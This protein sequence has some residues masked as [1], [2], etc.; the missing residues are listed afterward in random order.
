MKIARNLSIALILFISFVHLIS[1]TGCANIIPPS[2]GPRDSLPP[3]LIS[4]APRDS[5]TNF[6]AKTITLN[7]D[8]YVDI[9]N[10]QQNIIIS[11]APKY[12]PIIDRK[13]RTVTIKIK[14]TLQPNTTYLFDFGKAIKDVNEGNVLKNFSYVFTTGEHLDSLT[15]SGNVVIAESGKVDSTLIVMLHKNLDDSAVV[16]ERP[17]Y[18]TRVDTAGRFR[19]KFLAP[20][21]YNLYALKDEGGTRRYLSKS[22][23]FAFNDKPI[24]IQQANEPVTLYAYTEKEEVKKPAAKTTSKKEEKEKRLIVEANLSNN[25]LDLLGNLDIKF[26]TKLKTFD[27]TKVHFKDGKFDDI[28]S[29][30]LTRDTSNKLI[31]ISTKW[32][33][34]SAYHLILEKDF[35]EDSSGR[36]LLKA[37]TINFRTKKE[38]DYGIIRLRFR[39]LDVTKNPVLQFV[40]SNVVKLSYPLTTN[41][42]NKKLFPPGDYDLRIL[43]DDNQNGIWDA[44]EFFGKHKEPEKVVPII[45]PLR[46]K[47]RVFT[48]KASWENE[49]DF[50]L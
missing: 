2:G 27:S 49:Y 45:I 28:A 41:Q 17:R 43:Y 19:F 4:V 46:N 23:L 9:D 15:M 48:I 29:Y 30:Q 5:A 20:G 13:L 26:Q 31:T 10:A 40:Q 25:Q 1:I 16:N 34:D 21:T 36:K 50:T 44:G 33:P 6:N 14:D 47:K 8:E 22:S 12:N 38:S 42:F 32:I 24:V 39:N 7:F 18:V 3:R 11:P 35:A 37:D